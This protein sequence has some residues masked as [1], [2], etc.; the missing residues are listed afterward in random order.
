MQAKAADART[1][2]SFFGRSM[3]SVKVQGHESFLARDGLLPGGSTTLRHQSQD[4]HAGVLAAD[5][6]AASSRVASHVYDDVAGIVAERGTQDLVSA[7]CLLPT[8]H[9]AGHDDSAR[10]FRRL[11]P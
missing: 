9:A 6:A 4:R 1:A 10:N 3:K 11:V 8:A 5:A 7:K 2:W